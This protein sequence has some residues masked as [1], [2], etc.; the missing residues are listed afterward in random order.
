MAW[1]DTI[2]LEEAALR[3]WNSARGGVVR[4]STV[5]T[6]PS[7]EV[8]AAVYMIFDDVLTEGQTNALE[9]L[10]TDDTMD[11]TTSLSYL[12]QVRAKIV[13][14]K[15]EGGV[16]APDQLLALPDKQWR[17]VAELRLRCDDIPVVPPSGV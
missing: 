11:D 5:L 6:N 1:K 14:C 8:P 4:N 15:V 9:Q 10:L 3:W 13:G 16:K 7:G 2:S 17:V 12:S